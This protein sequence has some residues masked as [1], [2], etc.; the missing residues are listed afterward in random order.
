[1]ADDQVSVEISIEEKA[2]L[3]ALTALTRGVDKFEKET[4][5]SI[6]KTDKAWASFKGNLAAI[7]VAGAL[8]SVANGLSGLVSGS[9]EAAAS[10]EK[11]ST[12]L[13]VLTGNADVAASLFAELKE[14]SAGTPFQLQGIAEA[15]AQLISFGFEADTVRDRIG[16]IGE[17]AAGSGSDLKE[18][19]LI[20]GQVAAAGKLTGERLLQLQERAI[21]IGP[22][23]AKTMGVAET[24]VRKLV[25]SGQV[26]QEVFERAFNSMSASGGMFEGA[27]EKQSKT[28]LGVTST[29]KDNFSLLQMSIGDAFRPALVDGAETIIAALQELNGWVKENKKEI[30]TWAGF[31]GEAFQNVVGFAGE[32]LKATTPLDKINEKFL[33]QDERMSDLVK[34]K[35]ELESSEGG[36]F[37]LFKEHDALQLKKINGMIKGLNAEMQETLKQRKK[38]ADAG[39]KQE[40]EKKEEEKTADASSDPRLKKEQEVSQAI[41][42]LRRKEQLELDILKEEQKLKDQQAKLES[43]NATEA[44]RMAAIEAI[45]AHETNKA[46]I[47]YEQK[48]LASKK[49]Q[50]QTQKDIAVQKAAVEKEMEIDRIK[51][52]N[53]KA[54]AKEEEKIRQE[55]IRGISTFINQA[56]SMAQKG[57]AEAKV[58]N[59]AQATMNT[60]TA[61]TRAMK[62]YPYPANLGVAALTVAA[63]LNNVKKITSSSFA[64][65]GVVG[66]FNGSSMGM[67]NTTANVR[68][69]EMILNASQQRQLFEVA[70]NRTG[71]SEQPKVI[72]LTSIVQV[73]EREIARAVRNQRLEGFSI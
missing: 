7:G 20:Y 72:E 40:E 31:F 66:G 54:I 58:L 41:K 19:A 73:D 67:D 43:A 1:M 36:L 22:A 24:E 6:S 62:D 63:G 14:F 18:I 17:V 13:E 45:R 26:T 11:I 42:D 59:I 9:I 23:I 38:L 69:G 30:E 4:K 29:L 3:K 71:K 70:N 46:N 16:K 47:A 56:A 44:E 65:G 21:P 34:R 64:T 8:K 68:T 32:A 50:D 60:Y 61:A 48:V 57:T 33:E 53:K 39:A 12:Q 28:L 35:K 15:S 2:A 49:I 5:K 27:M 10:A 51:V 52:S 55:Q 25:S 37:G